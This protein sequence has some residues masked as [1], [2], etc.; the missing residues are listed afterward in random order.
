MTAIELS[1]HY[2]ELSQVRMHYVTAGRGYPIVLLH[3]WPQTWYEWRDVIP[4]LTDKFQVIASD[5]R[6]LGDTSRPESGY[7]KNS[8]A[9][10][11][12][13]LVHRNYAFRPNALDDA[14]IN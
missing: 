1:Q 3:G 10:D 4:L 9:A 13:E 7:D 14:S 5:L 2:A 11:V 12:W 6:G 8:L